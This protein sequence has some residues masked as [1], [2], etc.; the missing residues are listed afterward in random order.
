MP[1][2]PTPRLTSSASAQ[3]L[4]ASAARLLADDLTR[5]ASVLQR[6]LRH[7]AELQKFAE[8][9]RATDHE[10]CAFFE[11]CALTQAERAAEAE[12]LLMARTLVQRG[13][14][15]TSA[16]FAAGDGATDADVAP[17]SERRSVRLWPAQ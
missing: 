5:I 4:A 14:V 11:R 12:Q 10:L 15:V 16:A 9:A 2:E 7:A 6:A 3:E 17:S 13:E 8:D 1:S